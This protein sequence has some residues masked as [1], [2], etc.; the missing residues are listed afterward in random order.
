MHQNRHN[1]N[2]KDSTSN[3]NKDDEKHQ[4][5]HNANVKDSTSMNKDDEKN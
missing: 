4:T 2:V 1:I 3:A 5:R